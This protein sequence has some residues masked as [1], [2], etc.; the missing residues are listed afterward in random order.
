[1]SSVERAF[2]RQK[3]Q[4]MVKDGNFDELVKTIEEI[5]DTIYQIAERV[6]DLNTRLLK[7]E[8]KLGMGQVEPSGLWTPRSGKP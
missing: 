5:A 6:G 1:M 4:R 3:L 2:R 7:V 8:N